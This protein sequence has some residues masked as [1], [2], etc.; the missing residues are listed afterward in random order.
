MGAQR[1]G[2]WLD[3][4]GRTFKDALRAAAADGFGSVQAAALHGTLSPAELSATGRRHLVRHLADLGLRLDG[5]GLEFPEQG[6]AAPNHTER[7][8]AIVR[9]VVT[10]AHDLGAAR[11]A[12]RSG[13]F[14]ADSPAELTREALSALAELSDRSGVTIAVQPA[15]SGIH[16]AAE[17]VRNVGCETL[18][19]AVDT[20]DT[21]DVSELDDGVFAGRIGW[22][23]LRD[24]RRRGSAVEQTAYGAG[25]VDFERLLS[26]LEQSGYSGPLTL[27]TESGGGAALHQGRVFIESI[28]TLSA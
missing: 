19:V 2:V 18:C 25:D 1:I 3:S 15:D 27:R 22:V 12:V 10:L 28:L 13:G 7:R 20:L 8:L 26:I 17:K 16:E 6:L 4:Y 5:L 9:D 23:T 14:A 21:P 11:V 24:A